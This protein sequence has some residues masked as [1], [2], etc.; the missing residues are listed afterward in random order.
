MINTLFN[1]KDKI[2]QQV[3]VEVVTERLDLAKSRYSKQ[4]R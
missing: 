4:L 3:G 1:K 2:Q